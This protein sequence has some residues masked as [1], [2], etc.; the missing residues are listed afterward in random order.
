[1]LPSR[2]DAFGLVG[3]ARRVAAQAAVLAAQALHAPRSSCSSWTFAS[4]ARLLG[5]LKREPLGRAAFRACG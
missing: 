1:M 3:I 4:C 5:F 2:L